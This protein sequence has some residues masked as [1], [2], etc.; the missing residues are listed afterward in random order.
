[1]AIKQLCNPEDVKA[2]LPAAPVSAETAAIINTAIDN[3]SIYIFSKLA[4]LLKPDTKNPAVVGL[5][6][7]YLSAS[8]VITISQA[9]GEE[10]KQLEL[11]KYYQEEAE[12]LLSGILDGT[13][14]TLDED[15]EL[16]E[17]DPIQKM[18]AYPLMV[19]SKKP[20]KCAFWGCF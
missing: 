7:A 14:S 3:S 13:L 4:K 17:N 8:H 5:A 19:Y 1:M 15:G 12:K 9:G 18:P 11:S 20:E 16:T 6:C 10:N 2:L